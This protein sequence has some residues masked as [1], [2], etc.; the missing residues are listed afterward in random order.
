MTL[1]PATSRESVA[2]QPQQPP[3]NTSTQP[4]SQELSQNENQTKPIVGIIYPP[5]EHRNIIDKT[6]MFVARNGPEFEEK[7][8]QNEIS[9]SKF[10]FFNTTDPYHAYYQHKI[11][12]FRE[13]KALEPVAP[14]KPTLPSA[15]QAQQEKLKQ[16]IAAESAVPK[17][18]PPDFEFTADPPSISGLELDIVKLTAQFVARNGRHFLTQLMNRE[19]RNPQFDFLRPQ[20]GMFQY[21]TKLVEQYT[22]VL[23]PP[24]DLGE[25][26]ERQSL[27]MNPMVDEVKKRAEWRK[28]VE[29]QKQKVCHFPKK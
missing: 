15:V 25:M 17:E 12:E 8:R 5:P 9:N 21:F 4:E 14:Q 6:A 16:Q 20:H 7:V 19:Q 28:H 29:K 11:K 18:A 1:D 26:L 27:S 3:Q 10:N 22:K 23:I 24:K 2:V 13:G